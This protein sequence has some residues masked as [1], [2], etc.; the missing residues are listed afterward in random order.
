VVTKSKYVEE[1]RKAPEDE[2]S[3]SEAMKEVCP[4]D[5]YVFFILMV[6]R[7]SSEFLLSSTR[8]CSLIKSS[9]HSLELS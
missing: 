3:A 2:V 1:L 5:L 9:K 4:L 7:S 6:E 8:G